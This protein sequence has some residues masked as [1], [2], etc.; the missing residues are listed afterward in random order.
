MGCCELEDGVVVVGCVDAV[1]A[2]PLSMDAWLRCVRVLLQE[3]SYVDVLR[4][5][6]AGAQWHEAVPIVRYY[7]AMSHMRLGQ[8]AEALVCIET[9]LAS[10]PDRPVL[11]LDRAWCLIELGR[12][13]EAKAALESH[14]CSL[15]QRP[16]RLVLLARI[17]VRESR[18]EIASYYLSTALK[19]DPYV[20]DFILK[21][22][23]LR[24]VQTRDVQSV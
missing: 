10:E 5:I 24:G 6:Q 18:D 23:E 16:P 14:S 1:S 2:Q 19:M 8:W 20:V 21:F 17:A 3:E 11:L 15:M 22:D 12:C 4:L 7:E 13:S 9:L